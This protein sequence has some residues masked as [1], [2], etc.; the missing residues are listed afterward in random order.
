MVG[1]SGEQIVGV[2]SE[3]REVSAGDLFLGRGRVVRRSSVWFCGPSRR[4]RAGCVRVR[5]LA[6]PAWLVAVNGDIPCGRKA[7]RTVRAV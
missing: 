1:Q 7:V 6:P 2:V 4:G 3:C 5:A